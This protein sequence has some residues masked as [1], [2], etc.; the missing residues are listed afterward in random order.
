MSRDQTLTCVIGAARAKEADADA[1]MAPIYGELRALAAGLMRGDR[2]HTLQPTALIHEAYLKIADDRDWESTAHFIAVLAKAM[3]HVLID[4]ARAKH[5]EKRGGHRQRVSMTG[6]NI[7]GG[8]SMQ[9]LEE[10]MQRL[11]EHDARAG[12]IVELKFFGGLTNEEVADVLGISR[13]TV[14]ADWRHARAWLRS[15]MNDE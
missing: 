7:A 12:Q 14:L 13:T 11:E 10:A 1:M 9:F 2:A 5:A 15:E 4:H 3:R 6:A 8:T